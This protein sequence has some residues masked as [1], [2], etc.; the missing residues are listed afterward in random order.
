M[1]RVITQVVEE[2]AAEPALLDYSL[3]SIGLDRQNDGEASANVVNYYLEKEIMMV[4]DA[5]VEDAK[6]M[7]KEDSI[8]FKPKGGYAQDQVIERI[9]NTTVLPQ[10]NNRAIVVKDLEEAVFSTYADREGKRGGIPLLVIF[11][12]LLAIL[13]S[14]LAARFLHRPLL[15]PAPDAAA[16]SIANAKLVPPIALSSASAFIPLKQAQ[17]ARRN[18]LPM[19]SFWED[20]PFGGSPPVPEVPER[21]RT[22]TMPA[23]LKPEPQ[24]AASMAADNIYQREASSARLAPPLKTQAE[25]RQQ[26]ASNV[27]SAQT[28]YAQAPVYS[29]PTIVMSPPMVQPIVISL[30]LSSHGQSTDQAPL[31]PQMQ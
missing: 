8:M 18:N 1:N 20:K 12:G 2:T 24:T 3:S 26:S 29:Q 5:R 22:P 10:Q 25:A 13:F 4:R 27:Q 6:Q 7:V 16:F 19:F 30:Q 15:A 17:I 31:I 11:G 9:V 21:K 28:V 14:G 23:E